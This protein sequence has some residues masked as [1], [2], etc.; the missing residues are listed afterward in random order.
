[1]EVRIRKFIREDIPF[2]VEWIN[3]PLNNKYLHYDL[4]LEVTKTENWFDNNKDRTDRYDATIVVDN[5]PVGLIGIL[6]IDYKN[7]K[8]EYYITLGNRDYLGKGVAKDAS[9]LILEYAFESIGLNKIYLYTEFD[10]LGAQKLFEKV[11]FIR[12]GLLKEDMFSKDKYIDRYVYGITKNDF[13][14]KLNLK[15]KNIGV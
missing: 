4:P 9:R 1:M 7:K 11:G 14:K 6:G 3:N 13:A 12:E 5:I 10:N 15:I 2:K 8:G